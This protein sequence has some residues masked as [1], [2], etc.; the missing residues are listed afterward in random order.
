[1]SIA[2]PRS[3]PFVLVPAL[4]GL[5]AGCG[6]DAECVIDSDCASLAQRC[7]ANRCVPLGGPSIDL[8]VG[9]MGDAGVRDAATDGATDGA[10]GDAST[11]DAG[12]QATRVG[13]V[14]AQ[15]SSTAAFVLAAFDETP[16]GESGRCVVRDEGPCTV[17]VCEPGAGSAVARTAGTVTV[18]SGAQMVTLEPGMDARY[19]LAT[20]TMSLFGPGAALSVSATGDA[21]G[22]VPAFSG[23]VTSASPA[24]LTMPALTDGVALSVPTSGDFAVAWNAGGPTGNVEVNFNGMNAAGSSVSVRCRFGVTTFTGTVPA[25]AL[26]DFP[27]GTSGGFQFFTVSETALM[28]GD[29]WEVAFATR[30]PLATSSGA[31]SAGTASY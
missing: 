10:A 29:G 12:P 24:T 6:S 17:S 30:A 26:T 15:S 4:L 23:M 3:A 14:L 20:Q 13:A 19:P 18:T 11:G 27:A 25:A 21:D 5:L 7:E 8:G 2:S 16:A 31:P 1:M 9:D 22:G 28:P